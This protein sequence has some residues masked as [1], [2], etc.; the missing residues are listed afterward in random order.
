MGHA[1]GDAWVS[2]DTVAMTIAGPRE[3]VVQLRA[4]LD[5][6]PGDRREAPVKEVR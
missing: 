3:K 6:W 2:I 5:E 4:L 1:Y